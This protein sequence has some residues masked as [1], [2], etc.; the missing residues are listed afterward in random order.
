MRRISGYRYRAYTTLPIVFITS[1]FYDTA[2]V[3]NQSAASSGKAWPVF[4]HRQAMRL[5]CSLSCKSCSGTSASRLTR[6][7]RAPFDSSNKYVNSLCASGD[8]QA[9]YSVELYIF[10][11]TTVPE[12]VIEKTRHCVPSLVL[13]KR[14]H[15][16]PPLALSPPRAL[17]DPAATATAA[18]AAS[19]PAWGRNITPKPN[20]DQFLRLHRGGHADGI[21][22][23]G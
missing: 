10:W 16:H 6:A 9:Y 5:S 18:S 11:V 3:N 20:T 14:H 12:K 19:A 7:K 23:C 21:H 4:H 22:R 1:A 8:I 2:V 15:P 13:I 17:A